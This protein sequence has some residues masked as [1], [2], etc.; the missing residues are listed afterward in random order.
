MSTTH[1]HADVRRKC[2]C[3]RA[4]AF[5]HCFLF[6]L[7]I[8]SP[9]VRSLCL[10]NEDVSRIKLYIHHKT[11]RWV[12][13][14][15]WD[16]GRCEATCQRVL[17]EGRRQVYMYMRI[18]GTCINRRLPFLRSPPALI[19]NSRRCCRRCLIVPSTKSKQRDKTKHTQ[20]LIL[21]AR[22]CATLFWDSRK[23][24]IFSNKFIAGF[25]GA[26]KHCFIL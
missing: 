10:L 21:Y 16:A 2:P 3:S 25:Y 7:F 19:L 4:P 9:E 1:P 17:R 12:T 20:T 18:N 22:N 13:G 26:L 8:Y 15:H 23:M 14:A 24:S 5:L 11:S 6:L